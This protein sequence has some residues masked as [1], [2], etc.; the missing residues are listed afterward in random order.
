MTACEC[1]SSCA[2]GNAAPGSN[3]LRMSSRVAVGSDE[4]IGVVYGSVSGCGCMV[5]TGGVECATSPV[6][7]ATSAE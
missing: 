7:S 5:S 1:S 4:G 6:E 3:R 2:I